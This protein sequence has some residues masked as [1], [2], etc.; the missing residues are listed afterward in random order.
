MVTYC[1]I[2]S[3]FSRVSQAKFWL[4]ANVIGTFRGNDIDTRSVHDT[5]DVNKSFHKGIERNF[6]R[7]VSNL[8]QANVQK[9]QFYY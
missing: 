4:P 3:L 2:F 8:H 1:T 5:A 7:Y 9:G 6:T